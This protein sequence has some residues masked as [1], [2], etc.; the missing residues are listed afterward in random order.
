[1]RIKRDFTLILSYFYINSAVRFRWQEQYYM[2]FETNRF[3]SSQLS[4]IYA[5]HFLHSPS[6]SF[7]I[8]LSSVLIEIVIDTYINIVLYVIALLLSAY[9]DVK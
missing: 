3:M 2:G 5:S 4:L 7:R 8:L 9:I 1:M 6:V